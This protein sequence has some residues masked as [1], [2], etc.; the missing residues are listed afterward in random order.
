MGLI[1]EK[2]IDRLK[3]MELW[4]AKGENKFTMD[5]GSFK[6]SKVLKNKVQLNRIAYKDTENGFEMQFMEPKNTLR[7][8]VSAEQGDDGLITVKFYDDQNVE[9]W[10]RYWINF[11]NPLGEHDYGCGETYSRFDLRGER[12]VRIFVAEHQNAK[13]IGKKI[14]LQKIFGKFPGKTMPFDR[15]ESYY[16]QPTY[17][18]S[19]KYFMHADIK[20]FAEFNFFAPG[21]TEIYV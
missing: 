10:N 11:M 8:C 7:V 14:V 17:V 1:K 4:A 15:Y 19:K 21:L 5:R 13:R 20:Q 18:S 12:V 3:E 2:I 9:G 16:V 6:Y